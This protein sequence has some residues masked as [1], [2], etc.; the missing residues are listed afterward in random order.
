PF[1]AVTSK[2]RY[3][4][5]A[6]TAYAYT[7][8]S[9]RIKNWTLKTVNGEIVGKSQCKKGPIIREVCSADIKS[10]EPMKMRA[11]QIMI[12]SQYR[13]NA[14]KLGRLTAQSCSTIYPITGSI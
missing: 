3:S 2:M 14:L 4:S 6:R 8:G 7:C 10:V 12:G 11:N 9:M 1:K 5:T 13:Q